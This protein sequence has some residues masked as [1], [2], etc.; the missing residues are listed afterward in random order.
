[1]TDITPEAAAEAV[2]A[3]TPAPEL[4]PEQ[5]LEKEISGQDPA[6]EANEAEGGEGDL[7]AAKPKQTAQERINEL[8]RE[9]HD[10]AR[11]AE[12]WKAK[13]TA[14]TQPAREAQDEPQ[15][16]GKPRAEDFE[17]GVTDEGYVEALAEWKADQLVGRRFAEHDARQQVGRQLQSFVDRTQ[18]AFPDGEPDGLKAYR[19]I[20]KVP[21]AVQDVI[22]ASEAGPKIA[23]HFGTNPAELTS[24]SALPPH[25][26][27][28]ELGKLEARLTS[29]PATP[30]KTAS[31]APHPPEA[32]ARGLNGQFKTAPDTD[33]FAA[34]E[35]QYGN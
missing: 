18:A 3:E 30:A 23:A 7:P 1:M 10:A 15:G 2:V 19:A 33:D 11:E 32:T 34:F 4:T 5:A 17:F 13:A 21:R 8:T 35:K 9:K 29:P 12:F 14:P 16:D 6:A 25:L 24:L 26:Q 28:Y 22:L 31:D 27:A 20:D